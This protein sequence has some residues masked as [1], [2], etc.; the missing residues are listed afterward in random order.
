MPNVNDF[1][2]ENVRGL[3]YG[4]VLLENSLISRPLFLLIFTRSISV[5]VKFDI[6]SNV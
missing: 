6:D 3:M 4:Q 2:V 5:V 1:C